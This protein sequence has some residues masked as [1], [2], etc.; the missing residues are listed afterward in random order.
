MRFITKNSP[1]EIEYEP[2]IEVDRDGRGFIVGV[3]T[4]SGA[5]STLLAVTAR[6]VYRYAIAPDGFARQEG[7]SRIA[8]IT[9]NPPANPTDPGDPI[10]QVICKKCEAGKTR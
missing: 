3:K 4:K 2:Y 1:T 6:G 5:T 8:D 9:L 7:G 10:R